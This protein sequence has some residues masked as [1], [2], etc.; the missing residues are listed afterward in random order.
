M[1][2]APQG[3]IEKQRDEWRYYNQRRSAALKESIDNGFECLKLAADFGKVAVQS[4]FLLNG[5][6]L[7]AVPALL[8]RLDAVA[9][10]WVIRHGTDFVIGLFFAIV[11]VVFAY[12]SY[13][14]MAGQHWA[15]MQ[16]VAIAHDASF[17]HRKPNEM[18]GFLDAVAKGDRYRRTANA[19]A[20]F[21]ALAGML[22]FV[23][24]VLGV[25]GFIDLLLHHLAKTA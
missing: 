20:W 11:S 10:P 25:M 8:P 13:S 23:F 7:A 24:F 2:E 1:S 21:S 5:G 12:L 14:M 22:S 9:T 17:Q 16:E 3:F 6:A 19:F 15:E 4:A 18:P